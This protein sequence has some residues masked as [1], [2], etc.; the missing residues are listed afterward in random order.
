MGMFCRHKMLDFLFTVKVKIV[1]EADDSVDN[2]SSIS[3]GENSIFGSFIE[4]LLSL[5]EKF[6]N[7]IKTVI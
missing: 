2:D 1:G 3:I 5:F 4:Y 6:I 7:I